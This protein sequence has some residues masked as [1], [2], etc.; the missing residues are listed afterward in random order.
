[1]SIITIL[2]KGYYNSKH[3]AKLAP[4]HA[5]KTAGIDMAW[6]NYITNTLCVVV[7]KKS[8]K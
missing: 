6:R 3:A 7:I 8:I 5:G 4:H 1:M 2:R